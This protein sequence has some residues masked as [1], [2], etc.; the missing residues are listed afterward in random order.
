MYMTCHV[1]ITAATLVNSSCAAYHTADSGENR[2][3]CCLYTQA[4]INDPTRGRL[5]Q[6]PSGTLHVE[7]GANRTVDTWR[8][9]TSIPA[10]GSHPGYQRPAGTVLGW[11]KVAVV[12][13]DFV[14]GE[15]VHADGR[16]AIMVQN[17]NLLLS[18]LPTL[19]VGPPT[20]SE[21]SAPGHL[22]R[23]RQPDRCCGQIPTATVNASAEP[24]KLVLHEVSQSSG[25]EVEVRDELPTVAGL[26]ISLDAAE[27]RLFLL[28]AKKKP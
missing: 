9:P 16:G 4:D 10:G 8:C 24:Q 26:Q 5:T 7:V 22:S 17:F 3:R 23:Q 18:A 21:R 11:P 1:G 27:A 12:G 20:L 2:S 14:V 19:T 13:G 15:F 28:G 6:D 25:E